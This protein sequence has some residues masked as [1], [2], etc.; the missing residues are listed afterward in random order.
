M[1]PALLRG[2]LDRLKL[3]HAVCGVE[4]P[5]V[6]SQRVEE[7]K[8][9]AERERERERRAMAGGSYVAEPFPSFL[10][11]YLQAHDCERERTSANR[12]FIA[13]FKGLFDFQRGNL[14]NWRKW[15]GRGGERRGTNQRCCH[16]FILQ[17]CAHYPSTSLGRSAVTPFDLLRLTFKTDGKGNKTVGRPR[18]FV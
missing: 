13:A 9:R 1:K 8:Q 10:P 6:F 15:R 11:S 17:S 3:C 16:R 5:R 7:R 14:L 4:S 18:A 2:W 12:L